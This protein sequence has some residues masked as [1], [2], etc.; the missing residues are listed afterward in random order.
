[1][2]FY[3]RERLCCKR[4]TLKLKKIGVFDS[5]VGGL[6]VLRELLQCFPHTE[7]IYLG[8][9]ARVPYGIR[10]QDTIQKYAFE[11]ALFLRK[12][13]CE[14]IIVA[15]NTATALALPYLGN[16]LDLP[17]MGVVAP[18]VEM[19]L[20]TTRNQKIGI[21]GTEG[22]IGSKVYENLLKQKNPAVQCFAKA[23]PALVPFV[24]EG[25][26]AS[27]VLQPLL[28]YY[29]ADFKEQGIDTLILGCTHYP[30]LAEQISD[31]FSGQV[32][33][34]DSAKAIAASLKQKFGHDDTS[35]PLQ[36]PKIYVTDIPA[37]TQS[38]VQR[39]LGNPQIQAE[40]ITL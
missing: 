22:T 40:K 8:D 29:L 28:N 10:S 26:F 17:V 12:Q 2:E 34:V 20:Q 19:A 6:T 36:S 16:Q 35:S 27:E 7:F 4:M 18:G 14:L 13:G 33:L 39:I 5:G 1:M 32:Q 21:I 25:L 24:E 9:T 37:R 30:V 15:C 23:T 38:L 3:R 11:D 31:Y